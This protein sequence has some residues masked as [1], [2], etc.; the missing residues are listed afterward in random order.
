MTETRRIHLIGIGGSGLSAIAQVLI[1]RGLTVSGSDRQASTLAERLSGLGASISIGHQ[2]ANVAGADLVVRSSAVQDDNVEVLA[3]QAAGIPVLKRSQFLPDLMSGQTCLA[4]AG[5]H[6]KTTTTAMLAWALH[7]LGRDPSYIIG[8]VSSDLGG[9]AHAGTGPEFVIEADEYDR[10]FLG[11]AP[12]AALVASLEYDHPDCYPTPEEYSGAFRSFAGRIL[13]GGLLAVCADDPGAAQLGHDYRKNGGRIL[14]Y[15]LSAS[16]L[17]CAASDCRPTPNGGYTF[18]VSALSGRPA[19]LTVNLRVPGLHNVYNALGVLCLCA[20]LNLDLSAA[21]E[22]LGRFHGTGRRFEIRGEVDG[23]TVVDDYAHHPTEIRVTL[24]AARARYPGRR[25]WAVWQPHTYS[26]TRALAAD[27]AAAF[28]DADR[29]LVT[30]IF[31]AREPAPA[32]G[33]SARQAAGAIAAHGQAV[34]FASTLEAV[35]QLLLDQLR[36]GDV[37]VVL[38][39]GDADRLSGQ[40]LTEL[41]ARLAG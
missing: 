34:D 8:G 18:Q 11:L 38:S 17:D 27:F 10:M 35:G 1:E 9:N 13:P 41:T 14:R 2:A 7:E 25:V 15:G 22:A 5:T 28:A 30:E 21:A 6:G 20:G 40:V 32:D 36:A 19:P 33:F 23:V 24:T 37:L 29:V 12:Q 3:A 26:R 39:A 31:A 16:G 4:V